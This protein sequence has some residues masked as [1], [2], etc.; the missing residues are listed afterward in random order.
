MNKSTSGDKFYSYHDL[1]IDPVREDIGYKPANP[2]TT[3]AIEAYLKNPTTADSIGA[4]ATEAAQPTGH[5]PYKKPT[6]KEAERFSDAANG[7]N[8]LGQARA[9]LRKKAQMGQ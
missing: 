9:Q 4:I 8:G 2:D 7:P 1:G 3:A 6:P 5:N